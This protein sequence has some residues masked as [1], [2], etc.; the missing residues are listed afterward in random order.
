M[1]GD[2]LAFDPGKDSGVAAFRDG[3]LIATARIS[4]DPEFETV[5]R[6]YELADNVQIWAH[7]ID[8]HPDIL[9]CEWPQIYGV[10]KSKGDPNGLLALA[11]ACAAVYTL[12]DLWEVIAYT[13]PW[14]RDWE[15]N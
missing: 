15:T 9:V 6:A 7:R 4:V 2:L 10:Q 12:M 14:D 13:P 3:V 5:A 1:T 8:F 11:A